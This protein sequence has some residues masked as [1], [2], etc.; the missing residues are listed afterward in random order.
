MGRRTWESI[1]RPLPGR[2]VIVLTRQPGYVAPG[3]IVA[4]D[5]QEALLAAGDSNEVFVCGGAEVYKLAL[6]MAERL[7]LTVI[8]MNVE[9]D[10]LFPEIPAGFRQILNEPL[11]GDIPCS[12]TVWER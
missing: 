8:R 2:T 6:P 4:P 11:D 10:T 3:C 12:F 7:Y 9:G 5:M 1:G